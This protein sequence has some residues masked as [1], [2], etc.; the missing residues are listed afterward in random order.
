MEARR[1]SGTVTFLFT[2]I[3]GSTRLLERLRDRYAEVLEDHRQIVREAFERWNGHEV[4]TQGDSFFAA[5]PSAASGVRCAIEIQRALIRHRWPDRQSVRVRMGLHTGEPMTAGGGY[6][7]IDVHRGARIGAAAHGGQ[8]LVSTRTRDEADGVGEAVSF[9]SLGIHRFKGLTEAIEVFQVR[10]AEL[11]GTFP[12]IKTA[13]P[14]E[15]PPA[16]GPAPYKGLLRFDEADADRF[17]GRERVVAQLLREVRR[18]P[19]L[20]VVGASGSGKS[21][22]VRAGV[23]PA[24]RSSGD[25]KRGS[26]RI[27]VLTPT[28]SPL[29]SLSSA[30]V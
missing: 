22:I 2:D 24:L 23:I 8:I 7:G 25:R 11:P 5:F 12:A 6:V 17:F 20:A 29:G 1:P 15:E 26:W 3:E 10:T 30:V 9:E 28:G 4:D 16:P 27:L 19:F 18:Q 21:S 13:P 14:A